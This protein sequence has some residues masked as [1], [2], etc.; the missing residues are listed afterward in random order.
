MINLPILS[1]KSSKPPQLYLA[2]LIGDS[3]VKAA[4]W[5]ADRDG[6]S[7]L[8]SSPNISYGPETELAKV[9]D[10][11]LQHLGPNSEKVEEVVLGL[12]TN[13]TDETG[14]ARKKKPILKEMTEK[15]NLKPV[16]FV[17]TAEALAKHLSHESPRLS[18]LLVEFGPNHLTLSYL[19]QGKLLISKEVGR[20]A[21]TLA[22]MAEALARVN[23]H[24]EDEHQEQLFYPPKILLASFELDKE[25]LKAEQQVIIDHDWVNSHPF[26][27]MPTVELVDESTYL[28][29]IVYQGGKSVASA[30][31]VI[32]HSTGKQISQPQPNSSSVSSEA[33]PQTE[34]QQIDNEQNWVN[35]EQESANEP[36]TESPGSSSTFGIPLPLSS[37]PDSFQSKTKNLRGQTQFN[38]ELTESEEV[39]EEPSSTVKKNSGFFMKI[40]QWFKKHQAFAIVGFVAGLLTLSGLGYW[41]LATN[42]QAYLNLEL[43]TK[44]VSQET[45]LTLDAG[46]SES[47]PNQLILA[48]ST[49]TQEVQTSSDR[50]TTGT[51]LVG[52][53]A[54]GTV[55]IF[56]KTEAPK[57][58]EAGTVLSRGNL[59]FTLDEEVEVASASVETTATGENKEYGQVDAN[60]TASEIGAES[61]LEAETELQLAT[62]D[63]GT[64]SAVVKDNL[65]GGSSREVRVVSDSDQA[66]L[67]QSLLEELLE[68]A[69]QKMKD[70]LSVDERLVT[71][72]EY[73]IVE[74][75]FSDEVGD[76]VNTLK[77]S[78]TLLGK[79][80]S[81]Q[82][83]D[84]LPLAQE[85]LATD[86]PEGYTLLNSEP[87]ILSQPVENA[88]VSGRI[89]L[90]VN[91]SAEAEPVL[92]QDQLKSQIAG[93]DL[94]EAK[95]TLEARE[96]IDQ[97]VIKLQ[98]SLAERLWRRVPKD[99]EKIN[100]VQSED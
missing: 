75:N 74:E 53:A 47:D 27:Q 33:T 50:E 1:K 23:A 42:T 41:W 77:L 26:K 81:Y 3:Q 24:Y 44:S 45:S 16:G 69:E 22:D 58:F 4:L 34:T 66:K 46:R 13:W 20:S 88:T 37:L 51:K 6:V 63:L 8:E 62:F 56:N 89:E 18:A 57:T 31:G 10:E 54:Q 43:L 60:I 14:I 2:L 68:E 12:A 70:Q 95:Q 100:F 35:S 65:S 71:T 97:V 79:A 32:L 5:R 25:T 59:N 90:E 11:S 15:L 29:A 48:A 17:V 85:V 93:L 28:D 61:N 84:L 19:Q 21:Q 73:E 52:E 67:R 64:Y 30:A 38:S 72:G 96:T 99:L 92:D 36:S 91:L 86:L 87:Q 78:L 82:Q 40:M 39:M 83:E 49:R 94:R 55:T 76:E 7:L 98:P 80:L 9:V